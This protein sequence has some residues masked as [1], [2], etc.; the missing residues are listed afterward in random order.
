[1]HFRSTPTKRERALNRREFLARTAGTAAGAA[2]LS[3]LGPLASP[4][5]ADANGLTIPADKRGIILYTVR[6]VISRRPDPANGIG[7]GFAYVLQQLSGMGY[8]QVE[9]AGYT[10]D[11]SILGR[12]ITPA[13]IRQL[14]DDNGL[15]A[16]GSH[17]DISQVVN[18][19]NWKNQLDV[20][21]TLGMQHLGTPSIPTSSPYP[22]D[23][24]RV[25]DQFNQAGQYSLTNYGIRLYQHNHHAEYAFLLDTGPL[26]ANGHPTRSTG[27]RGLEYFFTV[28]DPKYVWF[29][30]DIYWAYVAQYRYQTYTDA[31]GNKA[32][33]IFDPI[34]TVAANP[35]QFPLFHVKDG[36]RDTNV[37]DGY[38]MVPAGT[39]VVPLQ[40]L[41][42]TIGDSGYHHPN[43]EQD[44]APGDS[45]HPNQSLQFSQI[46]YEN[47]ASW[48]G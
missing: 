33:N 5:L 12:Q 25:A 14:L 47:M 1:M 46:S 11:T 42:N 22:A 20:A 48:R 23:W 15:I 35:H 37:G 38:D 28:T 21:A 3:S 13:E 4:A 7:G 31:S 18:S 44:N 9:F 36:V 43:Y 45:A 19:D 34:A 10:Q 32:T 40:K 16:N 6:D 2:A 39:G 30:M 29:E 8:K 26:D 24:A 17:I 27:Q 41:L